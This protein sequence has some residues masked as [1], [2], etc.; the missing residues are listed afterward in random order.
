MT[1]RQIHDPDE[2][3]DLV[4]EFLESRKAL[5][6]GLLAKEFGNQSIVVAQQ[7]E[8]IAK[9]KA[10]ERMDTINEFED[11]RVADDGVISGDPL[12]HRDDLE[13]QKIE[14]DVSAPYKRR[15]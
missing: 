15:N 4:N 9:Q 10:L 11:A 13:I 1:F 14:R 6:E 12:S 5:K 8:A 2:F 7:E 3:E